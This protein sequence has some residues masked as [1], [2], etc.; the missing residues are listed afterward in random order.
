MPVMSNPMDALLTLQPAIDSGGVSLSPCELYNDLWV[1]VDYPMGELRITYATMSDGIAQ[2]IAQFVPADP[3]E[4]VPCFSLGYAV[5]EADR[6]R[7]LAT[8]TVANAI[9]ELRLG[10]RRRGMKQFYVEAIVSPSNA[11]SNRIAARLLSSSPV[12]VID[13]PSGE[14]ALQYLKLIEIGNG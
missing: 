10:L 5:L 11:P 14:P 8:K 9:S 12:S 2:A 1:L 13:A 7:G 3:V 6:G 4:G